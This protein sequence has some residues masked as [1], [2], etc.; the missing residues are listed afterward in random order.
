MSTEPIEKDVQVEVT[1]TVVV[2]FKNEE[3]RKMLRSAAGAPVDAYADVE[4]E[5]YGDCVVRWTEAVPHG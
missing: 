3:V 5:D 2:T 4:I 1:K